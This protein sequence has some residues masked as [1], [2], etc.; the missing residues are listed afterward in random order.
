METTHYLAFKRGFPL[1]CFQFR[2]MPVF[3]PDFHNNLNLKTS[4]IE[5]NCHH[6]YQTLFKR[7]LENTDDVIAKYCVSF[8][9]TEF[10]KVRK[11][12][13]TSIF[14]SFFRTLNCKLKLP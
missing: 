2:Q 14:S 7:L 13:Q 8:F 10:P 6:S 5:A 11:V 4:Y 3:S 12:L 1:V 9:D